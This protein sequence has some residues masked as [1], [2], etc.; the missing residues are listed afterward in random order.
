MVRP[1]NIDRRSSHTDV[2]NR[3]TKSRDEVSDGS[4][5][6][7]RYSPFTSRRKHNK[8]T[9]AKHDDDEETIDK[10]LLDESMTKQEVAPPIPT[11]V[12]AAFFAANPPNV[13]LGTSFNLSRV[14]IENV[15]NDPRMIDHT[16]A[17]HEHPG[18]H[19]VNRELCRVNYIL[20]N[21]SIIYLQFSYRTETEKLHGRKYFN[22][23]EKEH[24]EEVKKRAKKDKLLKASYFLQDNY[25]E[26]GNIGL[27][28]GE[29]FTSLAVEVV[30]S[31]KC[32]TFTTS[33][34]EKLKIG[35]ALEKSPAHSNS[36]WNPAFR[37][38]VS[39]I[40]PRTG[41]SFVSAGFNGRLVLQ[42]TGQL[43]DAAV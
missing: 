31:I 42:R 4:S 24:I 37:V 29:R 1:K 25:Y 3:Q 41:F 30:D 17:N 23:L 22:Y 32:L 5:H 12:H 15:R 28:K 10:F 19:V 35:E 34:R 26:L 9:L 40:V 2:N 16:M 6:E 27:E 7:I 39:K 11:A 8:S 38:T 33:D 36:D 21:G 13:I 14:Y 20:K 43:V 18:E